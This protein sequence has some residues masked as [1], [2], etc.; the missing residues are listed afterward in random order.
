MTNRSLDWRKASHKEIATA[1]LVA[2]APIASAT[3]PA[4]CQSVSVNRVRGSV[5]K[6]TVIQPSYPHRG[7]GLG[8]LGVLGVLVQ[9]CD[10][11][12]VAKWT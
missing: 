6:L 1:A 3:T 4:C 7:N 10:G 9:H 2:S 11:D 5:G 12:E 8:N